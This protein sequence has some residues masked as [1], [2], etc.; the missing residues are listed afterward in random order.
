[1]TT[2]EVAGELK[3]AVQNYRRIEAGGQNLTLKTV[4]KIAKVL[5]VKITVLIKEGQ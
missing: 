5:K 3:I 2:E 1:M 4:E